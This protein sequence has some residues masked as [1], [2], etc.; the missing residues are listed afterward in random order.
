MTDSDKAD[1]L[2]LLTGPFVHTEAYQARQHPRKY[3]LEFD[4]IK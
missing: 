2:S 3:T 4:R 1:V